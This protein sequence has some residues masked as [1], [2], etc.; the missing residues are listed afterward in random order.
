MWVFVHAEGLSFKKTLL[1]EEQIRPD[2]AR[3][4]ARWMG[5]QWRIAGPS[6]AKPGVG[7]D[8]SPLSIYL[9]LE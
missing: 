2:V 1:A 7:R 4:R 3:R 5:W 8:D 9:G 6:S